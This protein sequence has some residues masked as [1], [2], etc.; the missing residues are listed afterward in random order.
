VT[1][2]VAAAETALTLAALEMA[3]VAVAVA[4]VP[5]SLA[6]A[7]IRSGELADL[8]ATLPDCD[9]EVTAVRLSGKTGAA[10]DKVWEQLL[11]HVGGGFP[12]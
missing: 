5:A 7:R 6:Q 4:W 10:E 12:R 9:L 8:S 2:P 1:R 3:A 11:H